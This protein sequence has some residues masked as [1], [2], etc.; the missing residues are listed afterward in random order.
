MEEKKEF[1]A[2]TENSKFSDTSINQEFIADFHIHSKYSRATSKALDIKNLVKWARI[3]GV[4]VL[5]TGDFTHPDWLK[6][7]KE[8]LKE[9]EGALWYEDEKGKFPF[10]L[11]TELSFIYTEGRGRKVHL[12]LLAPSFEV[13]DKINS[14]L[15]TKGRRD[16][17]GRPIFGINCKDF[18]KEMSN[19]SLDIEVIPAH[20]WTPYF[21]VF[22]SKGGFDSLKEA[23]GDQLDRIHAIETGISSDP[24]MNLRIKELVDR[25]ISIVSFSDL[26]SFWPWRLGR[27][28]TIF[29]GEVSY[30]S[31]LDQIR[32]NSFKGTIETDPAYGKYHW[33]G[34]AKC[35]FS[36]SPQETKELK[37]I[38]P[39]C[40]KPL[41]IGV[42]NR[43]E[44]LAEDIK[45][46]TS[47]FA[48]RPKPESKNFYRL[49]PL[50]ELIAF[51]LSAGVNTKKVWGVYDGLIKKFGNEFNILL[52]V[53]KQDLMNALPNNEN[54]VK[55]IID[56]RIGNL[57]IQP[58]YDGEYGK[59]VMKE[60]QSRL[61]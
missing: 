16:Y 20:I 38:C 14:Y 1:I 58:G 31:I 5:G 26:H 37:G 34:H 45:E 33:D 59:I 39:E 4:D 17:D 15:D 49:V 41:T 23:F 57:K 19:I 56:N 50:H 44:E 13:V 3:K 25:N 9:E 10:I 40:G 48:V 30:K 55:A 42:D 47:I 6:E 2:D 35:G 12:V 53:E 29:F 60:E 54:L 43:V 61:F 27:E 24:D 18:V 11:S 52:K 51:N 21:G 28:A 7:L 46:S 22:G 36:C 8:N 32:N